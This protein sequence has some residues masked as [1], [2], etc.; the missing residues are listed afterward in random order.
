LPVLS[1]FTVG[2]L[3]SG[4]DV[5]NG[6]A[7]YSPSGVNLE[8]VA[9]VADSLAAIRR[10][11][12]EEKRV[13]LDELRQALAA[14]FEGHEALRQMLLSAAPKYGNDDPYVD[15][16]AAEEAAFYCDEVAKVP[17]P[18][19]HRHLPLLFGTTSQSLYGLGLKTG[20]LP[21]GRKARAALGQSVQPSPGRA[22]SGIT[23]E[24]NSV[25]R[26]DF[27]KAP[28]GVSYIIDLHPSIARGEEAL[29]KLLDLLR[30]FF[31]KGG[32]EIGLN[33]LDEEQLRQAQANP[34]QF[35]HL[36]VRVFGFSTQFVS[37]DRDL[38][39]LVIQ[40]TR[41]CS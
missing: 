1:A 16:I 31:R 38:Q 37:L 19:G 33:I 28:G 2:C 9:D 5:V 10:L 34:E 35:G 24:L 39:E 26:I 27:S 14:D 40:K 18:E 20:A 32:V 7:T 41:H 25:A 23:A 30:T 13:S 4:R 21:N 22:R 8:G 36:M 12:Y 17:T 11:V 15:Q 6:G 3:E 29:G